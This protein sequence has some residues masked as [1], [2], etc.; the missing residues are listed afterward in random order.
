MSLNVAKWAGRVGCVIGQNESF[1][2]S[3]RGLGQVESHKYFLLAKKVL[4]SF[5]KNVRVFWSFGM[6]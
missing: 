2:T 1:R 3:Q 4:L 5:Q 6:F